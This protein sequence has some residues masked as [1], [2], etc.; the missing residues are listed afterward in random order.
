[1]KHLKPTTLGLPPKFKAW[2]PGQ[3]EAIEAIAASPKKFFLLDAPTGAGKSVIGIG[4]H[5]LLQYKEKTKAVLDRLSGGDGILR[6]PRCVYV[7]RTKQLR[8]AHIPPAIPARTG[9]EL[10]RPFYTKEP[11]GQRALIMRLSGGHIEH[12]KLF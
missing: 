1:M 10:G 7:T 2:R 5:K 9:R 4:A 12:L 11:R 8:T 6:P 3:I